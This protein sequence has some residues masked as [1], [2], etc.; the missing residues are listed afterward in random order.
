MIARDAF[1]LVEPTVASAL[2]PAVARLETLIGKG[3][4]VEVA[5]EGL[6]AWFETFRTIQAARNVPASVGDWVGQVRPK[7]GP[8][9]KERV[10]WAATVTPAMLAEA[11]GRRAKVRARMDEAGRPRAA[12]F[13]YRPRRALRRCSAHP[14]TRSRSST[15]TRRWLPDGL[16]GLP[17]VSL[18]VA[19]IDGLPL[20]LSIVG[21]RGAD[22]ML[23]EV[24]SALF[25]SPH[26][27]MG[28]GLG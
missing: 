8:G 9:V 19:Q 3:E 4:E 10:A 20:G 11:N 12:P 26:S 2:Q 25:P 16:A 13:A 7:L 14:S 27:S 6:V 5:P 22:T 21:S 28:R 23:L 24:A 18:P 1:A 15:A 17:Q